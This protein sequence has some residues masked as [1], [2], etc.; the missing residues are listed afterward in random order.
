MA[1]EVGQRGTF[2]APLA[3]LLQGVRSAICVD[4]KTEAETYTEQE[5][6]PHQR[7]AIVAYCGVPLID[8]VAMEYGNRKS[9]VVV[10]SADSKLL[11]TLV[12]ASTCLDAE[13]RFQDRHCKS[14]MIASLSLF[15]MAPKSEFEDVVCSQHLSI[16]AGDPNQNTSR[17]QIL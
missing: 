1:E 2:A 5:G 13:Q 14:H 17:L 10:S 9:H 8:G 16:G 3:R 11:Q 15:K 12:A 6:M 4:R 7:H